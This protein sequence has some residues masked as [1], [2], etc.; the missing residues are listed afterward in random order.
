MFYNVVSPVI[1]LF[2]RD[3]LEYKYH[4]NKLVVLQKTVREHIF[5]VSRFKNPSNIIFF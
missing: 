1:A 4:V 5:N 2:Y 3:S